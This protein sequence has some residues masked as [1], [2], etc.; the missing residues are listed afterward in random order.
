MVYFL[1]FAGNI[2]LTNIVETVTIHDKKFS[3]SIDAKK[4]QSVV[5]RL[6]N[7][8]SEDL[9]SKDVVFVSIL[10]GSFMFA[11]DLYK[12]I[13]FLSRISFI[14]TAS[15]AG[16]ENT[17]NVEPLIGLNEDIKNKTVVLVEDIVDTGGTLD[18]VIRELDTLQPSDI[19]IATLLFKPDA[20]LYHRTIDYVGFTIPNQ[21]VIGYGLDYNGLG[22]N[23]ESIYTAIE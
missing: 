5:S 17:G 4:I 22:R 23:L 7:R 11:S 16:T 19:R 21:F 9:K 10:N 6:G 12:K 20:Y 18:W 8:I 1:N 14:K 15:Y 2:S 13:R 3:L